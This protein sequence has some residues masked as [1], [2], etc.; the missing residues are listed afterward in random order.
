LDPDFTQPK[1]NVYSL[2]VIALDGGFGE[3]QKKASVIVNVTIKDVN[4]KVSVFIDPGTIHIKENTPVSPFLIY[5]HLSVERIV[6]NPRTCF[7]LRW[8]KWFIN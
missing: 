6:D 3:N 8:A 4:N 7:V 2:T 1:T 5:P